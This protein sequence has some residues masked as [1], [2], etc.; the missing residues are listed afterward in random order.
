MDVY[1]V[2]NSCNYINFRFCML[3][4]KVMVEVLSETFSRLCEELDRKKLS[5]LYAC[6]LDEM[7]SLLETP[8]HNMV[9]KTL[10]HDNN[11]VL[12]MKSN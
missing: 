6:L 1:G 3:G 7:N 10:E 8:S 4:G 9:E 5:L 11:G 12:Q 2:M